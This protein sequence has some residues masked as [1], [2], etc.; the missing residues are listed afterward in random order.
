MS[1]GCAEALG[2]LQKNATWKMALQRWGYCG[3]CL[4][5]F[6]PLAYGPTV[7]PLPISLYL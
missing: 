1:Q 6:S 7:W 3:R 2:Y 5:F 4:N